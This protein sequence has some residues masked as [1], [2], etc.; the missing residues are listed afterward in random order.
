[1]S[2][3]L[4]TD[5]ASSPSISSAS[6]DAERGLLGTGGSG[7]S[8]P[9]MRGTTAVRGLLPAGPK[10]DR[11]RRQQQAALWS[12]FDCEAAS[13]RRY[14]PRARRCSAGSRQID[15]CGR[16]CRCP[17]D[18]VR[19]EGTRRST[20][21]GLSGMHPL[22]YCRSW[23]PTCVADLC[24][25]RS[26]RARR[27]GARAEIDLARLEM[28][29][30]HP[31]IVSRGHYEGMADGLERRR[32][33]IRS[34]RPCTARTTGAQSVVR[35]GDRSACRRCCTTKARSIPFI[36]AMRWR[37]SCPSIVP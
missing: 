12:A 36:I 31:V 28:M 21:A 22:R 19:H 9:K 11:P 20:S 4:G 14:S 6:G 26:S 8:M 27:R 25:G 37:S 2:L 18:A 30:V 34:A 23:P 3:L 7:G 13:S 24:L 35:I 29:A 33:A 32:G 10:A 17:A 1:M 16:H 5:S 15:A